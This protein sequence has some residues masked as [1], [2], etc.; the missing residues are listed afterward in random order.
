MTFKAEVQCD[1]LDC[2]RSKC[3]NSEEPSSAEIE[4][5]ELEE[6]GWLIDAE[7]NDFCPNCAAL[8]KEEMEN[9]E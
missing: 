4:F 6:S 7:G 5:Y 8:I 3:L 1:G 9:E 2:I